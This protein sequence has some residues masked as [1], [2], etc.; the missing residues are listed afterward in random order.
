[1]HYNHVP[2]N[3]LFPSQGVTTERVPPRLSV[4]AR[5]LSAVVAAVCIAAVS[6]KAL[7]VG[8]VCPTWTEPFV[9]DFPHDNT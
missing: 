1:M 4:A 5:H 7:G 3:V 6:A 8:T 9:W 2:F